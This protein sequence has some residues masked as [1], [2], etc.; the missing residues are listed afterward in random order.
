VL[1]ALP[2]LAKRL[3]ERAQDGKLSVPVDR[4][5]LD[6]LRARLEADH[7]RRD[8]LLL[9]GILLLGGVLWLLLAH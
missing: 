6:E 9:T 3:V 1:N 8:A 2:S 4:S 5:A 7:R